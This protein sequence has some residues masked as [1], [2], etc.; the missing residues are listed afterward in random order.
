MIVQE[1][2]RLECH[3]F[4]DFL[5]TEVCLDQVSV[6][7]NQ[8][9]FTY[10][11]DGEPNSC[12]IR[13][14]TVDFGHSPFKSEQEAK[15]FAVILA[16]LCSLRFGAVL[17]QKVNLQAYSSYIDRELL[18]F[19]QVAMGGHWSQHRYQVGKLDYKTPK[20]LVDD[21]QLGKKATYPLWSISKENSPVQ[22]IL[23]CGSGK[24]S[25][26]CSRILESAGVEY[27]IVTYFHD[28]Y[29]DNSDQENLFEQVTSH[30]KYCN[31]HGVYFNDEYYGWVQRR[32]QQT[33]IVART[34]DYFGKNRFRTEAGETL[35]TTVAMIPVQ[36]AHS[37][38]LLALGHEKSADAPNLVEP[39]S[40]EDV[41]H[42]WTKSLTYHKAITEQMLRIFDGVNSVSL[43][44]PIHDVK[45]FD[46]L[47]Q[48]DPTL[49][50]ATNSCNFQK[51]WCC[52]CEK[53][54]YVFSGFAAFGNLDKTVEAFGNN[55]L[56]MPENLPLW[57]DLL[58]LNGYIA[59]ECVGLPEETQLYFYKLYKQGVK[60]QAIELFESEIIQPLQDKGESLDLYFSAIQDRCSQVYETHHT[61]PEWLWEKIKPVL[62]QHGSTIFSNED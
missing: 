29:G 44:K 26:L 23:G 27:D 61:M 19:L 31:R 55:L 56:D 10:L 46:L 47:F 50:Y 48:L 25:L 43:T 30:L 42:Q 24:D 62:L 1:K 11:I 53:C 3:E 52:R 60:G 9:K 12:S 13:Y 33:N 58:G 8:L 22:V 34:K 49:P 21:L 16:V 18:D 36:V 41:S 51:P 32:L 59:W 28:I 54:C 7:N 6:N 38:P 17:P 45:I 5:V 35:L 20:L 14:N 37:I 4:D 40:G 57:S 2:R 15:R 39:E